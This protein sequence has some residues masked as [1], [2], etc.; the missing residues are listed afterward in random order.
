[1]AAPI[2]PR[3]IDRAVKALRRIG[4]DVEVSESKSGTVTFKTKATD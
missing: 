4:L 1:M 2:D 3:T